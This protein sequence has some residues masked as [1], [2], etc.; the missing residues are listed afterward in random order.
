MFTTDAHI[1]HS[2][3]KLLKTIQILL[4]INGQTKQIT[5]AKGKTYIKL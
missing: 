1:T 4:Q 2:S 5:S 3:I